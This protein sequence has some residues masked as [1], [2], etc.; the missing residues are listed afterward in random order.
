MAAN[1]LFS[2]FFGGG[3]KSNT[4][5][6]TDNIIKEY[7]VSLEDLYKGKL[8]KFKVTHKII[9]SACRGRGGS[10]GCEKTC[11]DCRGHGVVV[12]TV[13]QGNVIQQF[14][15][16]CSTCHGR[17]II[18]DPSKR[19]KVCSGMKVVPETKVIEVLIERGMKQGSKIVLPS[20]ADEAPNMQAGDIVYIVKEKKHP[21]FSHSGP[22]LSITLNISLAE[23]LCGFT[24]HITHLDGRRLCIQV[25]Q[26]EVINPSTV[27]VIQGEGMPVRGAGMTF[28]SLFVF[29]KVEFPTTLDT[30]TCEQISKALHKPSTQP[31]EKEADVVSLVN[32]SRNDYGHSVYEPEVQEDTHVGYH[33]C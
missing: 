28:G 23:A 31:P 13:R 11:L 14:Q 15:S 9:C 24:R 18:I 5:R 27:K 21:V 26:G 2:S 16:E 29:F 22:D 33:F 12:R 6:R 19:C 20:A 32:S 25:K 3:R 17:G 10:E 7:P 30:A 1:D 4:R 8:T